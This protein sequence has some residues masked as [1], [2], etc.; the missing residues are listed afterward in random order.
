MPPSRAS[1]IASRASVTVSIAAE[2]IGIASA[3]DGVSRVRGRDVVRQDARLGRDEQHVVEGE[4]LLRE[5]LLEREEPLDVSLSEFQLRHRRDC[6]DA[7]RRRS[8]CRVR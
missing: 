8:G 7:F 6:T 4:A 2:T 3:I 5:L 1:A